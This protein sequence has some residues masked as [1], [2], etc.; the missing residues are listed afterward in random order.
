M[1]KCEAGSV[2]LERPLKLWSLILDSVRCGG[3]GFQRKKSGDRKGSEKLSELLKQ[4]EWWEGDEDVRRKEESLQC[5]K[6]VA[7][8][9]QVEETMLEGAVDVRRLTKDDPGARTTLALLGVIPPLVSLLDDGDL[10]FRS[11]I[12]AMYALLNLAIGND[13]SVLFPDLKFE[14]GFLRNRRLI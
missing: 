9:L 14:L 2:A 3:G 10:C 1:G 5:L 4:P 11:Q 8:K 7:R 12:A 13:A 6:N